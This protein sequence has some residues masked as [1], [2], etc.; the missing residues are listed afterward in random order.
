MQSVRVWTPIAAATTIGG[1][2]ASPIGVLASPQMPKPAGL[3]N[4]GS[5]KDAARLE[6]AD[7][8]A[9]LAIQRR[10]WL[11]RGP[12]DGLQRSKKL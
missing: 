1:Y 11:Y 2:E 3:V 6:N 12:V 10:A 9:S 5:Y 8:L 4:G 7:T